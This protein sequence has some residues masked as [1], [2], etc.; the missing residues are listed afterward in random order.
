ML[1]RGEVEDGSRCVRSHTHRGKNDLHVFTEQF[2][3]QTAQVC[4]LQVVW[5]TYRS[6]RKNFSVSNAFITSS[7][8]L[9]ILSWVILEGVLEHPNTP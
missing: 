4:K 2:N 9:R 8:E 6:F 3:M 5:L 7:D 1:E